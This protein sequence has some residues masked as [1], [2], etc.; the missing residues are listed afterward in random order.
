MS[1]CCT[2]TVMP[3]AIYHRCAAHSPWNWMP[4]ELCACSTLTAMCVDCRRWGRPETAAE[5]GRTQDLSIGGGWVHCALGIFGGICDAVHAR[6]SGHEAPLH[7]PATILVCCS[8]VHRQ[9]CS[10]RV[11]VLPSL[12]FAWVRLVSEVLPMDMK[13]VASDPGT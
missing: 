3:T 10:T 2:K 13:Q 4:V 9:A 12:W 1:I 6:T 7:M 5:Q 11:D 8:S